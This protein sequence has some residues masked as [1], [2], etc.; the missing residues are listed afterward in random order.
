MAAVTVRF[1][2]RTG[3]LGAVLG[4]TIQTNLA[5]HPE[6]AGLLAPAVAVG[7][8]VSDADEAVTIRLAPDGVS[9]TDGVRGRPEVLIRADARSLMSLGAVPTRFHL[10]DVTKPA[11][12]DLVASLL[13]GRVRARG[14]V[15]HRKVLV[16]LKGLLGGRLAS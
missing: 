9:V 6:L 13:A 16:R 4:G 5:E 1:A 12:R 14:L 11:G 2:G 15:R 3:G 10:P 7:I 8:V